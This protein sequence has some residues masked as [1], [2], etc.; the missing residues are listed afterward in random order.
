MQEFRLNSYKKF[1]E[2]NNPIFGPE[3]KLDFDIITYYKKIDDKIHND[4]KDV[5]K[6]VKE[7]FE[8]IGLPEAEKKYLAG[9]GAQYES[10]VI[11]HN[12][13]KELEEKT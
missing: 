11:Y 4:W 1:L 6:D 12:M 13:I 9:V 8:S 2:L 7:T 5:P 3:L 10:E